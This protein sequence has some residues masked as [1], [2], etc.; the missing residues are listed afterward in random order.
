MTQTST[1]S[2]SS[3][4]ELFQHFEQERRSRRSAASRRPALACCSG[5]TASV[6]PWPGWHHV[7][8]MHIF[9]T[10]CEDDLLY[11]VRLGD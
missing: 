10:G 11:M 9:A 7:D 6:G 2:N 8:I 3:V 5:S 1:D 4:S